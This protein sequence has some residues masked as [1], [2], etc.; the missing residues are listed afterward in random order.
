MFQHLYDER[1]A[2]DAAAYL[3]NRSTGAIQ[4]PVLERLMYL[5]ERESFRCHGLPLTGDSLVS[6]ESGPSLWHTHQRLTGE[7]PDWQSWVSALPNHRVG[8]RPTAELPDDAYFARHTTLSEADITILQAVW[9]SYGHLPASR[10][11]DVIQTECREW[12]RS[13]PE[14]E[15]PHNRLFR[16]LGFTNAEIEG[17]LMQL[18]EIDGLNQLTAESAP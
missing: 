18:E 7:V 10:L 4:M 11:G 3:L 5:A 14:P 9:D 2:A 16:A 12:D 15:I 1:K 13:S 8:M 6:F 17:A